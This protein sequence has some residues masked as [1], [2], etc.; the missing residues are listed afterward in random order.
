M[1]NIDGFMALVHSKAVGWAEAY[2]NGENVAP[3]EVLNP[4]RTNFEMRQWYMAHDVTALIRP[5]AANVVGIV[6]AGGW[7]SMP[8]H[9]LSSK[10]VLTIT[11]SAG[12]RMSV[13]T[14]MAWQ[15]TLKGS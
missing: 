9:R 3:T 4:G 13:P 6:A 10:L 7:Q 14:T 5:G 12:N 11:D 1:L 15:G 8:G 2:I